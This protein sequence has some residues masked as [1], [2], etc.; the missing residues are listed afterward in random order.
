MSSKKEIY[1]TISWLE[2]DPEFP[3][4]GIFCKNG[5]TLKICG[6]SRR[7]ILEFSVQYAD[8]AACFKEK[9]GT[10]APSPDYDFSL[11]VREYFASLLD[12]F[13]PGGATADIRQLPDLVNC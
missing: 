6:A 2:E 4:R 11:L 7:R 13:I 9:Y 10:N 3:Q 5:K 1:F 8:I 12:F